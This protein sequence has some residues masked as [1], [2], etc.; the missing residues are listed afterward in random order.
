VHNLPGSGQACQTK[1]QRACRQK[2]DGRVHAL[3]NL[4]RRIF[5]ND[6]G[7]SKR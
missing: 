7:G 5:N 4:A 3:D 2:L 1:Q 6:N